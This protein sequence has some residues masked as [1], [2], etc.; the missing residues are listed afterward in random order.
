MTTDELFADKTVAKKLF[1]LICREVKTIGAATI[2]TSKSQ[3]TFRRRHNFAAVWMVAAQAPELYSAYMGV[4]QMVNT[5]KSE[6]L[7]HDYMFAIE[8]QR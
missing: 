3:I 4:A 5:L 8:T 6:K 2:Q 1:A 7:A